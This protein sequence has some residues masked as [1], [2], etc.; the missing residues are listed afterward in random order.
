M[1]VITGQRNYLEKHKR[2]ATIEQKSPFTT[3]PSYFAD[4][5]SGGHPLFSPN[6]NVHPAFAVQEKRERNNKLVSSVYRQTQGYMLIGDRTNETMSDPLHRP[7]RLI[8][9]AFRENSSVSYRS[10]GAMRPAAPQLV[11]WKNPFWVQQRPPYRSPIGPF[12]QGSLEQQSVLYRINS[13][14]RGGNT[15]AV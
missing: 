14:L 9:Q 2:N 4:M 6:T 13:W 3:I 15:N 11:R 5:G 8:L 12:T 7:P 10:R 1:P